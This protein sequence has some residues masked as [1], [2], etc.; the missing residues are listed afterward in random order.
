[1]ALV[2]IILE[3]TVPDID[4][5]TTKLARWICA[6]PLRSSGAAAARVDEKELRALKKE[7]R[8]H[9]AKRIQLLPLAHGN[10]PGNLAQIGAPEANRRT[11]GKGVRIGVIDTG[12]SPHKELAN[13]THGCDFTGEGNYEDRQGHGTHVAG[14]IAGK[15]TGVASESEL[16]SLRA[17]NEHGFG[18]EVMLIRAL[19]W[20]ADNKLDI[21]NLSLGSSE[22]SKF[23][24]RAVQY[25]LSHGVTLVAAAG[26]SGKEEY[27]YPA[28]YE[29]VVSV[30]AVNGRNEHAD[31]STINDKIAVSAPGVKI[32]SAKLGG[33]YTTMSGTSMAAPHVTGVL[34]LRHSLTNLNPLEAKE[35]AEATAY[36]LGDRH[37]YGAGLVRADKAV[38]PLSRHSRVF[39]VLNRALEEI[40]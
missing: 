28:S 17:L 5:F 1:M 26:N 19:E 2:D 36:T 27:S 3:S 34:G 15:H 11:R 29:G 14:T 4:E 22:P 24:K 40:L 32:E 8:L 16:Y 18:T 23:E 12:I 7:Y 13:Y 38:A 31:F 9:K 6:I 30:A 33:G 37:K 25:A 35:V 20:A 39:N 21:C 10:I